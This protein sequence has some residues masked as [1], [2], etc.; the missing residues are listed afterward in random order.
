MG[1]CKG[2]VSSIE[3]FCAFVDVGRL[4]GLVRVPELT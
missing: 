3:R 2:V 4:H 1:V